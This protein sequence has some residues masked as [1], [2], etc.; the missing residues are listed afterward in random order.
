M[1]HARLPVV[2]RLWFAAALVCLSPREQV[3]A[4]S[5]SIA[6]PQIIV[7][8]YTTLPRLRIFCFGLADGHSD[9]ERPG[10]VFRCGRLR[11]PWPARH[12]QELSVQVIHL[13]V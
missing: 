11:Q 2:P 7:H 1:R 9:A 3:P 4:L 13:S 8:M 12:P 6:I 10:R 5:A